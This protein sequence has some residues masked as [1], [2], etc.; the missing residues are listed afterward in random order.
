MKSLIT[1]LA[2]L[3]LITICLYFL[4]SCAESAE[5]QRKQKTKDWQE[6][7]CE[8]RCGAEFQRCK[9]KE[10]HTKLACSENYIECKR[11]C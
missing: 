11:T 2:S 4:S 8:P 7:R 10:F 5:T 6:S 3:V 1:G 9:M